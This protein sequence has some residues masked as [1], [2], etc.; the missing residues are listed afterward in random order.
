MG[1]WLSWHDQKYPNNPIP[2][3]APQITATDLLNRTIFYKVGHHASHNA[4]LCDLGLELMTSPHL[5]AMIPVVEETAKEQKSKNNPGGWAMPYGDLYARL[6]VKTRSRVLRGDGRIND[7]AKTFKASP[8]LFDL[9]YAPG[10]DP[11]WVEITT[12]PKA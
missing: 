12:P 1:N 4:T 7:E 6:N 5:T 11:L 10:S 3:D 8:G 2:P 9:A